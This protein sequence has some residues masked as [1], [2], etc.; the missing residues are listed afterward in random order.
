MLRT[1]LFLDL[2]ALFHLKENKIRYSKRERLQTDTLIDICL[3]NISFLY[4]F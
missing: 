4:P 3:R 1:Y 2:T